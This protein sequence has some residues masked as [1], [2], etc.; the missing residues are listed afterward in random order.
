M[1]NQ[2]LKVP[3]AGLYWNVG[4]CLATELDHYPSLAEQAA[5]L[6]GVRLVDTAEEKWLRYYEYNPNFTKLEY[7]Q[8]L[9]QPPGCFPG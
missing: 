1:S 3:M 2:A 9:A 6:T 4:M 5:R 8:A 7:Q